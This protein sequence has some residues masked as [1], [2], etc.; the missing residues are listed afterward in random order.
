VLLPMNRQLQ[1]MESIVYYSF[2][3]VY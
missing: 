2:S 3:E 1:G